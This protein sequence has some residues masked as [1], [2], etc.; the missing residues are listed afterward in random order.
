MTSPP[1]ATATR[2]AARASAAACSTCAAVALPSSAHP[3][4]PPAPATGRDN[5]RGRAATES[6]ARA[7]QRHHLRRQPVRGQPCEVRRLGSG[8]IVA[9]EIE[10]PTTE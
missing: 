2:S 4:A 8:R 3:R 5:G 1:M 9:S 10:A 6:D 7:P